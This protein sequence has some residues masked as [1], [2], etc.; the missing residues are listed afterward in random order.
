[1]CCSAYIPRHQLIDCF[2]HSLIAVGFGAMQPICTYALIDGPFVPHFNSW[3]PCYFNKFPDG[4][5]TYILNIIWL[6]EK[7][8]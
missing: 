2:I 3:E 4:P 8:P 5:Q 6:Q 7:E 1:M